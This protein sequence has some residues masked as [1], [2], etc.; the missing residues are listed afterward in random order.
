MAKMT[1]RSKQEEKKEDENLEKFDFVKG[2]N[3]QL[4]NNRYGGN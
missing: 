1:P 4:I 2:F 3:T